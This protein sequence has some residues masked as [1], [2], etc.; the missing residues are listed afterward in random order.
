ME[1]D[2]KKNLSPY[3][4][5][6]FY[7][8]ITWLIRQIAGTVEF[9]SITEIEFINREV[10]PSTGPVI[11]ACSHK[12]WIDIPMLSMVT[13]RIIRVIAKKELF[14][15]PFSR[16]FM[17]SGGVIKLDRENAGAST[18]NESLNVLN[19]GGV[20]GLYPEGER[21]KEPGIK[22][23][24]PGITTLIK[25][26]TK[27]PTIIPIGISYQWDKGLIIPSKVTLRCGS[28]ITPQFK[29]KIEREQFLEDL[30]SKMELLLTD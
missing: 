16:W 22:S 9:L 14:I 18:F 8:F 19:E 21:N 27:I 5:E 29:G 7:R 12:D 2:A 6:W 26:A 10:I 24:E 1:S 23:L 15:H 11:L 28:P 20:L 30:R 13:R 25:K 17:L 4:K 3:F